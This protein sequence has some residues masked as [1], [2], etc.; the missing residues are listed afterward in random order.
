MKKLTFTLI[1]FL[2]ITSTRA[3]YVFIPMDDGQTD[4]LKAYGV[5][6]RVLEL[7]DEI[8]WMLNYRG[9]AFMFKYRSTYLLSVTT[10]VVL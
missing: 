9:G 2:S 10:K 6:Y 7:N 8:F 1:I 3:N 5:A 4:H